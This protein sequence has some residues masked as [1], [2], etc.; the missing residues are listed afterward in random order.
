MSAGPG[1]SPPARFDE[2]IVAPP[3]PVT[4]PPIARS[5]LPNGMRVW[6]LP[7][8]ALPVVS[9][10]V[11]VDTGTVD[12]PPELPG[13]GA[14]TADLFDEGAGGRDSIHLA[15]ALADLGASLDVNAGPDATSVQLWTVRHHLDA[16]L[17][18]VADIITKPHLDDHDLT[19][20]RELRLSRLQQLRQSAASVADR[21]FLSAVFGEHGYGHP[22]LGTIASVSQIRIDDVRAHYARYYGAARVTLIAVGDVH[23]DELVAMAENAFGTWSAGSAILPSSPLDATV[24]R[25]RVVFVDRPGAPQS[26][27]RVGHL[28]VARLTPDYHALVL[29]NAGL[30]GSFSG[31]LNQRLRQQ[32]GYT[33]GA[34]SGFDMD[35][36]S[37]TFL[38][39]TSVQGDKTADSI[40]EIHKLITEV[41]TTRPLEGSELEQARGSLTRGYARHFETPRQLAGA[42]A[43][44]AVYGLPDD[45]FD[46]FVPLMQQLDAAA[47][48]SA[49]R[50]YLDPDHLITVVVGDPQW[51]EQAQ[52]L[53]API[54]TVTPEF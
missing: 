51:R 43:Q 27:I 37:G 40:R 54:E 45:T 26:E 2:P 18:V 52:E 20:V 33:Y 1:S 32:L 12:D 28:S 14:I 50:A 24:V 6:T 53:G 10:M 7:H 39:D 42:L 8:A 19:R 3:N 25:P 38:C 29:L 4:L 41:R 35:R 16:A 47:V 30:G 23:H 11:L 5:T 36:L 15:E 49:A 17:R 22:S 34:R 44:L 46:T 9:V 31:R 13:L 21:V 48:L